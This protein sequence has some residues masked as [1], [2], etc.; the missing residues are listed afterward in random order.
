MAANAFSNVVS[1]ITNQAFIPSVVDSVNNSNIVAARFFSNP[2]TWSGT[3]EKQPIQYANATNGGAFNGYDTFDTTAQ[4]VTDVL[5][6]YPTG[7]YQSLVL[8]HFELAA[9][10]TDAQVVSLMKSAMEQSQNSMMNDIGTLFYG[11]GTGK[12]FDGLGNAVDDGTSTTS[13]GG[14]TRSAR[15]QINAYVAAVSGGT[16]TLDYLA[17]LFDGASAASSVQESPNLML[18]TKSVFSYYESLNTPTITNQFTQTSM[19]VTGNTASGTAVPKASLSANEAKN[20]FRAL[21]WRGVPMVADD[22]ATSGTIIAVNERY[23]EFRSLA[24]PDLQQVTLKNQ[25]T[26]GVY[27][28]QGVKTAVQFTGLQRPTNQLSEIGQFVVAGDLICRQP[29]RQGK[30]TGITGV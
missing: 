18:T 10:K 11:L 16:L 27:S 13:Y 19:V 8:S 12:N 26:E 25:V 3:L 15:P 30:L 22:K 21:E 9:N 1:D 29:R 14:L 2:K 4:N 20:G 24:M 7:Y 5:T 6:W 17:S 23:W 28:E